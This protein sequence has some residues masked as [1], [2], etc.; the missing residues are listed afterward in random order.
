MLSSFSDTI[1][2]KIL[3]IEIITMFWRK[4]KIIIAR[5]LLRW[6]VKHV[7]NVQF[8]SKVYF[9][10]QKMQLHVLIKYTAY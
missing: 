3:P 5:L 6:N 7:E 4:K 10:V 8:K 9:I 2:Y 1:N